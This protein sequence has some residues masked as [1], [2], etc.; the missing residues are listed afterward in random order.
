MQTKVA[1]EIAA[2]AS[3]ARSCTSCQLRRALLGNLLPKRD[4]ERGNH[5]IAPILHR[6]AIAIRQGR[7]IALGIHSPV[8][9]T[10]LASRRIRLGT[11]PLLA[12]R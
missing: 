5:P 1:K 2:Y 12:A 3:N 9:R 8:P 6:T 4:R 11:A 10:P 7:D